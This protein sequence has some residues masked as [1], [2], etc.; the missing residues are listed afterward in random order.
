MLPQQQ[1]QDEGRNEFEGEGRKV[2]RRGGGRRLTAPP[3]VLTAPHH[4]LRSTAARRILA[5]PSLSLM[6]ENREREKRVRRG[7]GRVWSLPLSSSLLC[8]RRARNHGGST[9]PLWVHF[10]RTRR[11]RKAE[12]GRRWERRKRE[13]EELRLVAADAPPTAVVPPR[14]ESLSC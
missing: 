13:L 1:L 3:I 11:R 8:H 6:M 10:R 9:A 5:T 7:R 14:R 4:E 12:T 2:C